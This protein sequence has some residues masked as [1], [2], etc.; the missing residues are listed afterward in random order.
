MMLLNSI[1]NVLFRH[2]DW[3]MRIL[4]TIMIYDITVRKLIAIS[5]LPEYIHTYIHTYIHI[6]IYI[7]IYRVYLSVYLA[8]YLYIYKYIVII[9]D[10]RHTECSNLTK[11]RW[12]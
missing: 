10:L 6:Y 5:I 9:S 8:I 11:T 4:T 7:Y 12:A 2:N 1:F 3:R